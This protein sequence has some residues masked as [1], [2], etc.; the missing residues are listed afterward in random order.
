MLGE[1]DYLERIW[2]KPDLI[3]FVQYEN[4]VC[5]GLKYENG[6]Y[7]NLGTISNWRS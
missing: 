7:N 2:I 5:R 4:N 3:L 1:M 6:R